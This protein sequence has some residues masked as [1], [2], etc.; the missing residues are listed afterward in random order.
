M[1]H[2][3]LDRTPRTRHHKRA[4]I[5][6]A[7]R[8][9]AIEEFSRNGFKGASTQ[10]IA[11]LAGLTKPQLHYYITSKEDLFQ[12]LLFSILHSWSDAFAFDPAAEDPKT[13]LSRYVQRKLAYALDNPQL[14]RIFTGELL[15]GGT[16]LAQYWPNA[17][18]ST[19]HKVATIEQWIA[20]GRIRP[21]NAL[22]FI[23]QIW[24]MTQ[25]YADY[26][27]QAQT[28]MHADLDAP[29]VRQMIVQELTTSVLLTCGLA[30]D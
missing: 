20:Q 1:H 16:R 18:A 9:A 15:N 13:V 29:Q 27:L 22:V 25:Y 30:P 5:E 23:Q 21:L 3:P 8:Q 24:G 12:E 10:N 28:M 6:Q 2:D 4:Q 19:E 14:S 17:C 26:G 11:A 7:I